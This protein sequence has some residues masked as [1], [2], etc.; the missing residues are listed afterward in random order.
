MVEEDDENPMEG[1]ASSTSSIMA[2]ADGIPRKWEWLPC[3]YELKREERG[4]ETYWS[5]TPII[6]LVNPDTK[7]VPE[8]DTTLE[9]ERPFMFNSEVGWNWHKSW[10]LPNIS[11][12]LK[13][14]DT[15][16]NNPILPPADLKA[17]L[18]AVKVLLHRVEQVKLFDLGLKGST[19]QD[20]SDGVCTFSG[21]KFSST[22]YNNE[23]VKF[24]LIVLVYIQEDSRNRACPKILY[25]KISPPIFVDSRKAARN[26]HI[27]KNKKISS[28]YFDSFP[29][30]TFTRTFIKRNN[31]LNDT[32]EEVIEDNLG[33]LCHYFT[34]P[35][36]RNKIKHP[37]FLTFRFSSCVKLY[38][39]VDL[40]KKQLNNKEDYNLED[41]IYVM[42][43][44]FLENYHNKKNKADFATPQ[45]KA[46][47]NKYFILL[48]EEPEN[49]DSF[50][51]NKKIADYLEPIINDVLHVIF[52]SNLV[53]SH[54]KV[55]PT[56]N[57]VTSYTAAYPKLVEL[58]NIYGPIEEEE[59]EDEPRATPTSKHSPKG[60]LNAKRDRSE[61]ETSDVEEA[62]SEMDEEDAELAKASVPQKKLKA[63]VASRK[64]KR[65]TT[66]TGFYNEASTT[67]KQQTALQAKEEKKA[68]KKNQ[69]KKSAAK[70]STSNH[71]EAH[72]NNNEVKTE[73][74]DLLLK[75][76]PDTST[77]FYDKIS[78]ISSSDQGSKA[79]NT[80]KATKPVKANPEKIPNHVD[81]Y[82]NIPQQMSDPFLM[83]LMYQN[84]N[85]SPQDNNPN[86]AELLLQNKNSDMFQQQQY[87]QAQLAIQQLQQQKQQHQLLQ[88]QQQL[89]YM[90]AKS[91]MELDKEKLLQQLPQ[92]DLSQHLAMN[93]QNFASMIP[94]NYQFPP[95]MPG[96]P[97]LN[98]NPSALA[99]NYLP[100][101]YMGSPLETKPI[102]SYMNLMQDG[103]NKNLPK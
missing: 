66:E 65:T 1:R 100:P 93:K 46:F 39:N 90:Q 18:L 91:G 4:A 6:Q 73:S 58:K 31:K 60:G 89:R 52:N 78:V 8:C 5:L 44:V 51:L 10:N 61:A 92:G 87:F 9:L 80:V 41:L 14:T 37:I 15:R 79:K 36:I 27:H 42:Q 7:V 67:L 68:A 28:I 74:E 56:E 88:L 21:V 96:F 2:S 69:P 3:N 43:K 53:P 85:K 77:G 95:T 30:D 81:L 47:D 64:S 102:P 24:H 62:D 34:A 13:I 99:E 29:P 82:S 83:N 71:I 75:S 11:V 50:S 72:N 12:N 101:G 97:N 17:Q 98:F 40:V 22:S 32:K 16:T 25:S 54:F 59:D 38:Y 76:E 103:N 70:V 63:A 45:N 49:P 19:I 26:S 20:L 23:G 57:L 94:R 55:I 86:F 35:N 84:F 33:G 48:I